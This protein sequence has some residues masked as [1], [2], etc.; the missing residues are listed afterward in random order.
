[1][2]KLALAVTVV[3]FSVS[4]W[5]QGE[6]KYEVTVQGSG[7]FPKQ[8]TDGALTNKPTSSGGVM[9][10]LRLNLSKR[11]AFEGDYDYFRNEEKFS[12]SGGLTRIPMDVHA[13]TI[14]GIVRLP[15]LRTV[16]P[17][18]RAGGGLMEFEPRQSFAN[19]DQQRGAFVYG[20]GLDV[21]VVRRVALRAE[22]RGFVYKVPDFDSSTLKV[23]KYNHAAVPSGGLVLTF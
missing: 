23:G 4:A 21:P 13:L 1:M 12:F 20:G 18:L 8:A 14:S 7:I 17:F 3:M 16:R 10:G 6:H 22:Y 11:L 2:R 19:G 9:A 15:M 5:A